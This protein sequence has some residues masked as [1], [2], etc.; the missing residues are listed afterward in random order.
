[1][2]EY[3]LNP[4][5]TKIYNNETALAT[6]YNGPRLED[7]NKRYASDED[8]HEKVYSYMEYLYNRLM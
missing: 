6:Y 7:V 1:M 4:I 3:Y 8:W 2:Q 5:G